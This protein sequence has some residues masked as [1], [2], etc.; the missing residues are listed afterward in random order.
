M[1]SVWNRACHLLH[2][3]LRAS[4]LTTFT[5]CFLYIQGLR[6]HLRDLTRVRRTELTQ[7]QMVR[8]ATP[9]LRCYSALGFMRGGGGQ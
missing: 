7:K 2:G 6:G 1:V 5:P 8:T 9:T 4:K 3:L